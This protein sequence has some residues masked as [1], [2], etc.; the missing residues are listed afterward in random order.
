[1]TVGESYNKIYRNSR[2]AFPNLWL[3][4]PMG[5]RKIF[6]GVR[7]KISV[8]AYFC[9][10]NLHG[11]TISNVASIATAYVSEQFSLFRYLLNRKITKFNFYMFLA[12]FW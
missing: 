2:T 12:L 6:H 9:L 4:N 8:M 7:G 11:N 1:V 10:H 5:V 3:D